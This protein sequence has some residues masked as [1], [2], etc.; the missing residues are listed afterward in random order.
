MEL[1]F[2]TLIDQ[3][4][5]LELHQ[6]PNL[7]ITGIGLNSSDI[8]PGD[9]FVAIPGEKADGH[10]FIDAAI[11]N[12]ASAIISNGRNVGELSVPQ[13]KVG[14]PR[15]AASALADIFFGHPSRELTVVGITGTNG[16]TTVASILTSILNESGFRTA[17]MGTLGLIADGFPQEKGLTTAD[18]VTLHQTF[19][20]LIDK[21]FTHVIMEVSSHALSQYR[22]ADVQFDVG[23]FTNLTPEHLDYH[24]TM[25]DYF[26]AKSKLFSMLGLESTAIINIDDP[27]GLRL[28]EFSSAPTVATS[29]QDENSIH[30]SSFS[31]SIDGIVGEIS[32]GDHIYSVQSKLIG[33]FNQENIL[34]AISAAHALGID[35]KSISNGLSRLQCVEGR[36]ETI[37]L[38]NGGIAVID[39]AH[40]PDAY[41]KVLSTIRE[42]IPHGKN[43]FV[44]FGAGGDRDKS[45]R[46]EMARI[47][48][49]YC[50]HSFITPDN[51]RSEN[52]DKISDEISAGFK[53]NHYSIH[54]HRGNGLKKAL[55]QLN[56]GDVV[57]V[58]GKGRETYQEIMGE[59]VPYSDVEIIEAFK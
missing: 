20:A 39:Y 14:N 13:V 17:Q 10:D 25:E 18:P 4:V 5:P 40:T 43:I 29:I 3:L 11:S 53:T 9:V 59:K 26:L 19:R 32:A 49:K 58:L 7:Q 2:H 28:M 38:R 16:K 31:T 55:Q 15:R 8:K 30:Y 22:V 34:L 42:I 24:I 56:K 54:N 45:K 44:V 1:S 48:E 57:V 21:G 41:E 27:S 50:N 6:W 35:G 51:P 52:P 37:T 36:M 46:P 12:G 33:T 47:A 23:V